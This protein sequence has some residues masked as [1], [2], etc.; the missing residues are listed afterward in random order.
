MF[1]VNEPLRSIYFDPIIIY[2][3]EFNALTQNLLANGGPIDWNNEEIKKLIPE[4]LASHACDVENLKLLSQLN[5]NILVLDSNG[6]NALYNTLKKFE[7]FY[8]KYHNLFTNNSK[9]LKLQNNYQKF[10]IEL[11]EK[12][13]YLKS[14]GLTVNRSDFTIIDLLWN[15]IYE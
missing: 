10:M 4:V 14:L 11:R 15:K 13:Q 5:C 2:R 12:C 9:N 8:K 7:E 6:K 1:F 3:T